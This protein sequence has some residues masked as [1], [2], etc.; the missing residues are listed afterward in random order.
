M[1]GKKIVALI[2]YAILLYIFIHTYYYLDQ[3]NNCAC[4]QTNGK[5]GVNIE[6]MKFFQ[7]LEVFILTIYVASMFLFSSKMFKNKKIP[8]PKVLLT[9]ALILLLGISLY[10]SI[11]VINLY[12]NIKDDCKCVDS[13][14]RFFLYYEG[15]VSLISVF[16]FVVLVLIL[17]IIFLFGKFT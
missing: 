6:F 8:A 10:M 16:R 11:N 5:Y 9:L 12:T 7:V 15:I 2:F 17:A 14:Y 3:I 4:F 1:E 13:W